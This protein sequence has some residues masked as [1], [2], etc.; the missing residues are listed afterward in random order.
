M[1]NPYEL[2]YE[3][4]IN[5][6]QGLMEKFY[7]DYEVWNNWQFDSQ[8]PGKCPVTERPEIPTHERVLEEAEKIYNFVQKKD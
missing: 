2:R 7:N 8:A 3:I 5:A 1:A 4:Y 6:K